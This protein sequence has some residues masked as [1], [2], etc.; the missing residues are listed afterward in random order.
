MGF[1]GLTSALGGPGVLAAAGSDILVPNPLD[2]CRVP[3]LELNLCPLP[4]VA[5][6]CNYH[7]MQP[8]CLA[9]CR[10]IQLETAVS[11]VSCRTE[12]HADCWNDLGQCAVI[13]CPLNA[14][15]NAHDASDPTKRNG[16]FLNATVGAA[17]LACLFQSSGPAGRNTRLLFVLTWVISAIR[18]VVLYNDRESFVAFIFVLM[19]LLVIGIGVV[20]LMMVRW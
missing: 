16:L 17:I 13:G 20:G 15:S 5:S 3:G 4:N 18:L 14:S 11:C 9:C 6:P 12:F 10:A 8:A 19:F 1:G 7:D 2:N